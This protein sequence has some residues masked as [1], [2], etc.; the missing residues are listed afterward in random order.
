MKI[1]DLEKMTISLGE[2]K[3]KFK[4]FASDNNVNALFIDFDNL[5]FNTQI[6]WALVCGETLFRNMKTAPRDGRIVILKW[7]YDNS[8][9][10]G[11]WTGKE[12]EPVEYSEWGSCLQDDLFV[13]WKPWNIEI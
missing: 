8:W 4:K 10:L 6:G 11:R 7:K 12:W 3:S 1:Q 9:D 2:I 5:P 13:G